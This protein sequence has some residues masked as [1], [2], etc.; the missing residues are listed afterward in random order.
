M[1]KQTIILLILVALLAF[2]VLSSVARAN[3][4]YQTQYITLPPNKQTAVALQAR[5]E[6]TAAAGPRATNEPPDLRPSATEP[7]S[8][9]QATP[10]ATGVV[11]LQ[12]DRF[13]NY[14]GPFNGGDKLESKAIAIYGGIYYWIWAGASDDNPD[15]GMLRVMASFADPCVSHRLGLQDPSGLNLD[16]TDYFLANGPLTII[17]VEGDILIYS[18]AGGGSGRFNVVTGQFLPLPPG[19]NT[20]D[21]TCPRPTLSATGISLFRGANQA[22]GESNF[23]DDAYVIA[24]TGNVYWLWAGAPDGRPNQGVIRVK[25]LLA[26]PCASSALG[27]Q[28]PLMTDYLTPKGPLTFTKIEGDTMIYTIAG[29][30][31]GRFNFVTGTFLP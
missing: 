11:P 1:R 22:F 19:K 24:S 17:K 15:L 3:S 23:V 28:A 29:G 2:A 6:A 16:Y 4:E 5:D 10:K 30:G 13:S 27:T 31:S 12:I 21:S 20:I 14:I 26:D 9:P 18:I 25:V 8:C 7:A